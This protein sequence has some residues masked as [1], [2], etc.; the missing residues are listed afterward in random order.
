MFRQLALP[1]L[2]AGIIALSLFQ[3]IQAGESKVPKGEKISHIH[4]L[5]VDPIDHTMLL[6]ATHHGLL[7]CRQGV[8]C[9]L[10]GN[11][12]SDYMGFSISADGKTFYA[13][14]HDASTHQNMGLKRST[15]RGQKWEAIAFGGRVDFHTMT[16]NPLKP[17]IIYGWY[18]KLYRSLDGG[19]IWDNPE[20]KGLPPPSEQGPYSPFLNILTEPKDPNKVFAATD[21]GLYSSNDGGK[22]W[23]PVK[24]VP[25]V[26]VVSIAIDTSDRDISYV[27]ALRKGLMKS[28]DGMKTWRV[29]GKGISE[30]EV[31]GI[32]AIDP[33]SKRIVY[34]VSFESNVYRSDDGGEN[35]KLIIETVK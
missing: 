30:N 19:K 17:N 23:S 3:T 14:G 11:D 26:P 25:P 5:A 4:G 22:S 35:F 18:G 33:R 27:F 24:T 32:L 10:L 13:S 20:G 12:R 29:A 7:R 34:A 15:D 2:L 1:F 8:E 16:V 6:I 21:H 31:I 9:S 28:I